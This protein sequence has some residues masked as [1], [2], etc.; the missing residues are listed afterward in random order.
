[1][2]SLINCFIKVLVTIAT[3]F[4]CGLIVAQTAEPRYPINGDRVSPNPKFTATATS[5]VAG[6]T[7]NVVVAEQ[8]RGGGAGVD[9]YIDFWVKDGL[10]ATSLL[11]SNLNRLGW[12]ST[13]VKKTRNG[14]YTGAAVTVANATPSSLVYGKKY[15]WHIVGTNGSKSIENC[16]GMGA[17]K[18]GCQ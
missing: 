6:V 16:S 17:E 18:G 2:P 9:Q 3:I 8:P 14:S 13:W 15:Y 11:D 10:S 1:M 4:Y 12:D 5:L 7:Y